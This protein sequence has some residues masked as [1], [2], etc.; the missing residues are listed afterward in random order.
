[1][2]V[3]I[4]FTLFNSRP[5][6]IFHGVNYVSKEAPSNYLVPSLVDNRDGEVQDL[7][8]ANLNVVRLGWMWSGFNPAEGVL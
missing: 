7:A 5:S 8:D 6:R 1:M 4:G 3:P 2:T